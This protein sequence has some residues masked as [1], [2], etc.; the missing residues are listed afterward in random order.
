MIIRVFTRPLINYTKKYHIGNK[1]DSHVFL[2]KVFQHLGNFYNRQENKINRKFLKISTPDEL[3]VKPLTQDVAIEKGVEFFYEV[4]FYMI[5]ITI[6]LCE[7]Y[8]AQVSADEKSEQ[9]TK[10]LETI[11]NN[12]LESQKKGQENYHILNHRLDNIEKSLSKNTKT[13]IDIAKEF[14][15]L[16]QDIFNIINKKDDLV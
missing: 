2:K 4:I 6:P 10:R 7:M 14:N 3:F 1:D 12:I 5:L 15:Y 11:E 8:K 13:S 16:R 9:L